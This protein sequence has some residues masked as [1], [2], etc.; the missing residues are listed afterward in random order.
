MD[1]TPVCCGGVEDLWIQEREQWHS[2]ANFFALAPGK[3]VGYAR[4][5]HTMEEMDKNGFAIIPADE[6]ITGRKAIGGCGALAPSPWTARNCL[7]AAAAP[8]A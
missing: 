6:I 5:V 2:G 4:N 1:L 3:V 7:A 8:G